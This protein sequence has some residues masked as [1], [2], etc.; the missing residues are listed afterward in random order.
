[1]PWVSIQ[2]GAKCHV[3]LH[4]TQTTPF[5]CH[6]Q[7]MRPHS[8][9]CY[10]FIEELGEKRFVAMSAL[11]SLD[12]PQTQQQYSQHHRNQQQQQSFNG[13][14]NRSQQQNRSGQSA[15]TNHSIHS[16]GSK[17]TEHRRPTYAIAST[18]VGGMTNTRTTTTTTTTTT[19]AIST[20]ASTSSSAWVHNKTASGSGW[21][22]NGGR[23]YGFTKNTCNQN[24][25]TLLQP[26]QH[27]QRNK[28]GGGGGHKPTHTNKPGTLIGDS[29]SRYVAATPIE[30]AKLFDDDDDT[31]AGSS[32]A[33]AG[34]LM[35]FNGFCSD[36][37]LGES[38]ARAVLQ[39]VY[40]GEE[41]LCDKELSMQLQHLTSTVHF[42]PA[43]FE[44]IA[45]PF[46]V[47]NGGNG[48]GGGANSGGNYRSMGN[49]K[50]QQHQSYK[51]G[52]KK[53]GEFR[54]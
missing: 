22:S 11:V 51:N 15:L 8:G 31:V 53:K 29:L 18:P 7:E 20:L 37:I 25:T 38:Q 23:R 48:G 40:G 47:A 10:V 34:K 26:Q 1:M 49:G 46:I 3:R 35:Q 2:I 42:E 32:S 12:A 21:L 4:A 45:A 36:A 19:T 44:T 54:K 24:K 16:G 33:H 5:V 43:P 6:I 27:E 50:Q 17:T 13:N 39:H 30:R 14:A 28:F 41:F 9:K 52:G